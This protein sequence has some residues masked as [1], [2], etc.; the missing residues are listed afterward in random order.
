MSAVIPALVVMGVTACGKS[1]VADAIARG[2]GGRHIEGDQF[3][4]AASIAKMRSGVALDDAGRAAWLDLLG[5]LLAESAAAGERPV[6]SCSALKRRY[7]DALR[8]AVPGLGFV[9]LQLE[10]DEVQRRVARRHGHFMAPEL[11]DS[12]FDT[13]E[14]PVREPGVLTVD[15]TLPVA[16]IARQAVDWWQARC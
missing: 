15:A 10:R 5:A 2:I 13:L 7:R 11:V 4:S 8:A 16:Q 9:F 3:H 1:T 12:Q 14:S 6:L